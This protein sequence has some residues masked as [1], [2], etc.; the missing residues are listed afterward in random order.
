MTA[1]PDFVSLR[2]ERHGAVA[3]VVLTGP[4]RGNAV[5]PDFFRELPVALAALDADASVR[6]VIVRGDGGHFCYGLDL[7]AM[8]GDLGPHLASD[9][10]A[11]ERTELHALI[12]RMQRAVSSLAECRVPVIAAVHGWC[13][14]AGVDL[15]TACDVRICSTDARFSVREVKVAIVA[16]VGTLQ[17]L[18]RIV[19]QGHARQLAFTGEDVDAARA[20]R[21]GLVND[22]HETPE[23]LLAAARAMAGRIADNPPLAVEGA[24]RVLNDGDG[25]TVAEGLRHVALW[26]SAFLQSHDLTEAIG[27]FAERRPPKFEGR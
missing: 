16:D 13:I 21:L 17:R 22:V 7:V 9:N 26:N 15:I 23:A 3:E 6:A 5:G 19:G 8:A 14:G 27:A 12:T 24:K 18:P 25:Q 4:G 10:R 11:R 20:L 2:V 1:S